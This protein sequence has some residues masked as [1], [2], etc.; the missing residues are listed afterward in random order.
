MATSSDTHVAAPAPTASDAKD[1][2]GGLYWFLKHFIIGPVLRVFF[3]PWV[4]GLEH[5]PTEGP[6][7]LASL[8]SRM[9]LKAIRLKVNP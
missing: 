5:L 2:P 3:R 4:E 7:I 8:A 9:H 1:G 6:A